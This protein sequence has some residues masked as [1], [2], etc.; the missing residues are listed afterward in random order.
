MIA[1][2]VF[3]QVSNTLLCYLAPKDRLLGEFRGHTLL[4]ACRQADVAKAKKALTP[5]TINF[6]VNYT[7]EEMEINL[8]TGHLS[9]I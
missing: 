8:L 1:S 7:Y 4:E 5:D 9:N 3:R 2:S 6:K